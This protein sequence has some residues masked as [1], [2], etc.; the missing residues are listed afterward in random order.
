[1]QIHGVVGHVAIV[2]ASKAFLI[3]LSHRANY[4]WHARAIVDVSHT[5][6]DVVETVCD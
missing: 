5:F 1:M 3:K 2:N 4:T 6:I